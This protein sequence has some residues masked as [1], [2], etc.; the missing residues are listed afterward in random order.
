MIHL[1]WNNEIKFHFENSDHIFSEFNYKTP[2][3]GM[4]LTVQY[5]QSHVVSSWGFMHL[6]SQ[7][8]SLKQDCHI[9]ND[10]QI[11]RTRTQCLK[12]DISK[13]EKSYSTSSR[14]KTWWTKVIKL[15][16]RIESNV[17][18]CHDRTSNATYQQKSQSLVNTYIMRK[19][20]MIKW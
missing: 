4:V 2:T 14:G 11:C 7:L 16:Y 9:Q 18:V 13:T 10:F 17:R 8:N 3:S 1:H 6:K 20:L 19:L 12:N 5:W 15:K